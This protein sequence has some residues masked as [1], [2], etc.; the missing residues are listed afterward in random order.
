MSI[1]SHQGK[2]VSPICTSLA[3]L[4]LDFFL[5]FAL[6]FSL[7]LST[8]HSLFCIHFLLD[9][10]IRFGRFFS[11]FPSRRWNGENAFLLF[12]SSREFN[13]ALF[14]FS[15]SFVVLVPSAFGR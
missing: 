14:Y 12:I 3:R 2:I 10:F 8:D 6:V 7:P 15:L 9:T 13:P 11:S 1:I 4:S 5:T